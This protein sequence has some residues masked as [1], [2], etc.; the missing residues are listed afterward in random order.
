MFS[1]MVDKK[2]PNEIRIR[3]SH[4]ND[5]AKYMCKTKAYKR[6][7]SFTIKHIEDERKVHR[8]YIRL[9]IITLS[10][11]LVILR[12][13]AQSKIKNRHCYKVFRRLH[14]YP[15]GLIHAADII[16][17]LFTVWSRDFVFQQVKNR[18]K[19][20]IVS[21][22]RNRNLLKIYME[23]MQD[24]WESILRYRFLLNRTL[25][26]LKNV[27]TIN[28]ELSKWS[29]IKKILLKSSAG[30]N[31]QASNT[32]NWNSFFVA[33]E[34]HRNHNIAIKTEKKGNNGLPD[35]CSLIIKKRRNIQQNSFFKLCRLKRFFIS[36]RCQWKMKLD[37]HRSSILA[38]K[39]FSKVRALGEEVAI[40]RSSRRKCA[41][42]EFW[43][44]IINFRKNGM[45]R[46]LFKFN[47]QGQFNHWIRLT[48]EEPVRR[49]RQVAI[50]KSS[51]PCDVFSSFFSSN[52]ALTMD[53]MMEK[54][55]RERDLILLKQKKKGLE[56]KKNNNRLSLLDN[57][58]SIMKRGVNRT[59]SI[60]NRSQI[61]HN[62]E[63]NQH[64]KSYSSHSDTK[65]IIIPSSS[66]SSLW[67]SKIID[68]CGRNTY[69]G[70]YK[71][72]T[73]KIKMCNPEANS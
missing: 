1:L 4:L 38:S 69:F 68:N 17:R 66:I 63:V 55:R 42:F 12:K 52:T 65:H 72:K 53:T 14:A 35:F 43:M 58:A 57:S 67:G 16:R 61:S 8:V 49:L 28:F 13:H 47:L 51:D 7:L 71:K 5:V 70:Q 54:T 19:F 10:K 33:T 59:M 60:S 39:R 36:W 46:F 22:L 32:E 2:S 34:Q 44:N 64:R 25:H 48:N 62:K 20:I 29:R 15:C 37:M 31:N 24:R 9:T 45:R 27:A 40:V 18:N 56:Q 11:S 21:Q 73:E 3:E 23:Y 26:R 30:N 41:Y 50:D 6:W